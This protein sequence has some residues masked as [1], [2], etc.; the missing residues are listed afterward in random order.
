MEPGLATRGD[1]NPVDKAQYGWPFESEDLDVF[2]EAAPGRQDVVLSKPNATKAEAVSSAEAPII[3]VCLDGRSTTALVDTGA[4]VTVISQD[5]WTNIGSPELRRPR[6]GHV[7]AE[8]TP[9]PVL[10][11]WTA[12][13]RLAYQ[14]ATFPVWVMQNSVTPCILDINILRRKVLLKFDLFVKTSKAPGRTDLIE[15]HINTAGASPIKSAPFRVTQKEGEIMEAEIRQYL[16]LGL[17]RKSTSPWASPVLMI[18]KP[19][20][21][22][23]FCIDYRKLNDVTAKDCYPMHRVD[24]LLDFLGKAK[25]FST[26]DVASGYW[27]VRMAEDSIEKT[28]FTCKLGLYSGV[29]QDHLWRTCLVYLDDV[30]IFSK[31]FGSH[32][33]RIQQ[34]L[35][36][37]QD[38]GFKL[39]MSKCQWG[40]NRVAFLGHIITLGGI[41]LNPEKVKAVLRIR[42]LN[43]VAQVRSFLGLTGGN[44]RALPS[45][46]PDFDVPFTI[47]VDACPIALGA[48]LTQEQDGRQRVIAY[49]SQAL[50]ASQRKWIAKKDGTSEIECYGL[51]WATTKFRP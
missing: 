42:P 20:G 51:V 48:V 10:G 15:C 19:D 16:D 30:I 35:T 29:L 7:S 21:S 2:L 24:D 11:V 23:R 3:H 43:N 6:T 44:S 25:Y 45:W 49:A 50:D 31:D 32:L 41:L 8:N 33:V 17:I 12:T 28:A 47:F 36:C 5:L 27:N 13:V 46:H 34:V 18:R 37:L 22:I 38:A 39:K 9:M 26:M 1:V 14:D 4:S 40:R